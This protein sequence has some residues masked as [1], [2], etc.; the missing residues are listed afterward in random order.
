MVRQDG[1]VHPGE[2]VPY[3]PLADDVIALIDALRLGPPMVCGFSDG[4][5]TATVDGIRNPGS[6]RAIVNP[7]GPSTRRV[8]P[9]RTKI[10]DA[11]DEFPV[12]NRTIG[13]GADAGFLRCHHRRRLRPPAILMTGSYQLFEGQ[14]GPGTLIV[15]LVLS[16]RVH[17]PLLGIAGDVEALLLAAASL[18]RVVRL[19][20]SPPLAEPATGR[21]PERFDVAFEGVDFSYQPGVPTPR[22]RRRAGQPSAGGRAWT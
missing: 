22:S 16:L 15:F 20:E 17:Q 19:L 5:V 6:L 2:S 1:A 11:L 7:S 10:R 12:M 8:G 3:T 13:Q 9:R 14:I 21:A 18:A 4:A